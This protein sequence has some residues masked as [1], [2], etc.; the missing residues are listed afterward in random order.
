MGGELQPQTTLVDP[1]QKVK[2]RSKD[3][4]EIREM[5]FFSRRKGSG[6]SRGVGGCG[7]CSFCPDKKKF[8]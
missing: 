7:F 2:I 3:T 4:A 5:C 8:I 1:E 6:W